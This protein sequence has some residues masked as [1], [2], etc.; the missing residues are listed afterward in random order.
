MPY[1]K[2][3]ALFPPIVWSI[4]FPWGPTAQQRLWVFHAYFAYL[5][6]RCYFELSSLSPSKFQQGDSQVHFLAWTKEERRK[7]RIYSAA[8]FQPSEPIVEHDPS[9]YDK[10]RGRWLICSFIFWVIFSCSCLE[11]HLCSHNCPWTTDPP[12]HFSCAPTHSWLGYYRELY[13]LWAENFC[14]R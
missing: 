5:F 13:V 8:C 9:R 3:D 4:V 2:S 10:F 11:N 7:A 1:A 14:S 12:L 6:H